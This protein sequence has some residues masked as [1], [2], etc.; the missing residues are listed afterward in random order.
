[1]AVLRFDTYDLELIYLTKRE[2]GGKEKAP[3]KF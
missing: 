1:M 3:I 2:E